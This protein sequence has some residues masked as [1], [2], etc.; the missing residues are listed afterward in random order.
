MTAEI[1]TDRLLSMTAAI[2]EALVQ[3]MEADPTVIVLGED[4][5]G[6][7]GLGPGR[8]NAMGGSFG[9][10]KPLYPRFGPN[11]VRDTPISEAAITGAA[12]GAAASG[13]RPVVD[14]MW[15]DFTA[16]AFDQIYNQAA[17][18]PYMVGGQTRIP[19]VIRVAMGAGLGAAAQHSGTLYSIYAHVPGLKVVVPST[20]ADAKGLL[21]AAIDDDDPVIFFEHLLLYPRRGPVPA[22]P[23]RIPLGEACVRRA[24]ADATVVAI[25]AMV[26]R[27]LEAAELLAGEGIDVE[28]IDPRTLAP[29]DEATLVRSVE[30]TG[31]MLVVD[32]SPPR[33]GI[34]SEIAATVTERA[35]DH[36][37]GPV[38][39]LTAPDIP[40]P[41]SPPLESA[42]APSAERIADA[43]RRMV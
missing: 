13:L 37:N 4:V 18:M 7:A 23:D 33:C 12:V 2:G 43:V 8:E 29:L 6:G 28:V 15:A 22:S 17:K 35:F 11:R 39:R 26:P 38:A 3:A 31:S 5:A 30:K 16:L 42:Y 20:P 32:E 25:A 24:G 14:L 41:F 1:A 34:A 10:T 36:L 40:V 19:L 27:A 9:V 21:L